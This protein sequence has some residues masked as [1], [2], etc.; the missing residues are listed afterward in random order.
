MDILLRKKAAAWIFLKQTKRIAHVNFTVCSLN[1]KSF[2][3]GLIKK[4]VINRVNCFKEND[5]R[6]VWSDTTLFFLFAKDQI[7]KSNNNEVLSHRISKHK[8]SI[9]ST[10]VQTRRTFKSW[11]TNLRN[12]Q[13][14]DTFC[15]CFRRSAAFTFEPGFVA[16]STIH[17]ICNWIIAAGQI[18]HRIPT[19]S[20]WHLWFC[21]C[22][23]VWFQAEFFKVTHSFGFRQIHWK[24]CC[25]I[26]WSEKWTSLYCS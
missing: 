23:R 15:A 19:V 8:K 2:H 25:Q 17:I 10:N 18:T 26:R 21:R 13:A 3:H 11:L 6:K 20:N 7:M 24:I 14:T 4:D 9:W 16:Y 5:K 1:T 22:K 12:C